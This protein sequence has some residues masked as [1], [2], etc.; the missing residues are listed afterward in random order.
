M[1]VC[2]SGVIEFC[3]GIRVDSMYADMWPINVLNAEIDAVV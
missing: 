3:A 2:A 1:N